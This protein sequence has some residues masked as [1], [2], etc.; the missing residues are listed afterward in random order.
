MTFLVLQ[1]KLYFLKKEERERRKYEE[2][3]DPQSGKDLW[4]GLDMASCKMA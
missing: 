1:G 2:Q 3:I 4:P